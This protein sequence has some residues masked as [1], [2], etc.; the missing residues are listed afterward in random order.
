M[1]PQVSRVRAPGAPA[2][3]PRLEVPVEQLIDRRAGSRVA[4]LVD[5]V[6]EP[7][8]NF[9]GLPRGLRARW[10]NFL[11]VVP[12][13]RYRAD[14]GVDRDAQRTAGELLDAPPVARA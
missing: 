3:V 14:A 10:N 5:L 6:E 9:L 12:T 7:G 11:Q 13:V 8:S 2:H 1:L 4:L